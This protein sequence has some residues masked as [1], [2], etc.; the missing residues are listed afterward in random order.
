MYT[1]PTSAIPDCCP[2][3]CATPRCFPAVLVSQ[4]V[5]WRAE[6]ILQRREQIFL[7]ARKECI[8][9]KPTSAQSWTEEQA[10]TKHILLSRNLS[11]GA[12]LPGQ[13]AVIPSW[14]ANWSVWFP[15]ENSF[16]KGSIPTHE[17]LQHCP[18]FWSLMDVLSLELQ[19]GCLPETRDD[20]FLLAG[21]VCG[22]GDGCKLPKTLMCSGWFVPERFLRSCEVG[23][24]R[25]RKEPKESQL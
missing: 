5:L 8:G 22:T 10:V 12:A 14:L 21:A 19:S 24:K 17:C 2:S 18:G 23:L 7:S 13:A 1:P 11:V 6:G 9:T 16:S 25:H 3:L 4:S 20:L 15:L